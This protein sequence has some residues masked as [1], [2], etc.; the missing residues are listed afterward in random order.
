MIKQTT[1]RDYS[2]IVCKAMISLVFSN[3]VL[4]CF[5]LETG[6]ISDIPIIVQSQDFPQKSVK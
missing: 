6:S 2:A 4:A 5:L 1:V 3:P